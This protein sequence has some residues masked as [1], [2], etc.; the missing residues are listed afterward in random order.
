MPISAR[1]AESPLPD[2]SQKYLL[3]LMAIFVPPLPIYLL[4]GP[5]HTI[6]T[7]EFFLSCLL[8]ILL[9]LAGVIYSIYFVCVWFPESKKEGYFPLNDE[10]R[11]PIAGRTVSQPQVNHAEATEDTLSTAAG[12]EALPEYQELD[13]PAPADFKGDNKVQH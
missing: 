9:C 5:K 8:T 7:K 4:T 12:S 13:T 1:F 10:E 3:V 2:T 11:E 6:K